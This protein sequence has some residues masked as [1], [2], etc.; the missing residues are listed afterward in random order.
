ML[1]VASVFV[2]I[3]NIAQS[4][5]N[6]STLD[7]TEQNVS[8]PKANSVHLQMTNV[9]KSSSSFHPEL[10]EFQAAL[11]LENTE[12]NIK[13]FGYITIP[14]SKANAE[15]TINVDQNMDIVDMDQFKAYNIL[16]LQS[17]VFR[18]G[19]RGRTG[20]K[21]NGFRKFDVDYNKAVTMKG[22]RG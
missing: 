3:P 13:P 20:L 5:V 16:V 6:K 2:G 22:K 4:D 18:V 15:T 11:F 7:I 10:D 14:A 17:E 1:T 21:L 9:A 19:V 8:D 12:P